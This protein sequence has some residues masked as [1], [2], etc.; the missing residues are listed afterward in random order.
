MLISERKS[1]PVVLNILSTGAGRLQIITWLTNS[2]P[3][4][5]NDFCS[6]KNFVAFLDKV[7]FT[8]FLLIP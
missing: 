7:N 5:Q 8:K 6:L 2:L 4:M 3:A 1:F